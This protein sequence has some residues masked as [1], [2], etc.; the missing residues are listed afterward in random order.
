[1]EPAVIDYTQSLLLITQ[2]LQMMIEAI[3]FMSGI[4]VAS[5]VAYT[6]KG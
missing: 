5:I 1:M 4:G 6:W 3:S 2:H